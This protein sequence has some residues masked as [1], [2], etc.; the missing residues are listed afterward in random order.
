MANKTL[1]ID[2]QFNANVKE[3]QRQMQQL[4][5]SLSQLATSQPMTSF[6]LTPQLKEAQR[7]AMDLKIA[8]NNAMNIDTGRLNLNK[9]QSELNRS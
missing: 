5:Q 4:Q 1:K 3:A 2:L 9:F 6:S 8:L 7:S